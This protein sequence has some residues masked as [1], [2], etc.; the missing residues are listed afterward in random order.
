MSYFCHMLLKTDKPNVRSFDKEEL[1][2]YFKEKGEKAFRADQVYQWVWQKHAK[3]FDQ[4]SNLP[5]DLRAFM[6]ENFLITEL[7]TS[8]C[9]TSAD[10][11]VKS[12]FSLTDGKTIEGVL[13][14]TAKRMTAC[15][16]SQAGCS[17]DC[18]FCATAQL[19]MMR[20]LHA[21]EI[22][23][24]VVTIKKQAEDMY[25]KPLT[26]IVLMGMGEPLLNYK[27]VSAAIDRITS[28]EGLNMSTKR[29]TLSTSGIAKMIHKLGDDEVK[30]K[31]ALS[32]HAADNEK[33]SKIMS[34]NNTNPLEDL[35]AALKHYYT[36][37]GNPVTYEYIVFKDFNDSIEDAK[38]LAI[39]CKHIPSKVNI[40]EYN[41]IEGS[42]FKQTTDE[43][44]SAFVDVLENRGIVAKVR[45][46]RGKDIDAACGQLAGKNK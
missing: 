16:S 24:Q 13:I 10:G 44:L 14:P 4:M 35:A 43:R 23:D 11:T 41:P 3:S 38:N 2:N 34:I 1:R 45:R 33:R 36:K 42:D 32:L 19:K 39:F 12:V 29:I 18:K 40:I 5:K 7:K 6:E 21:D 17:L 25:N 20:N 31:L 27:N 22:Y 30:F 15:I 26:N 28:E 9:Q 46:S 8:L 37:T